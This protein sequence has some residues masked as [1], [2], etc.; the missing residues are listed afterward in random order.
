MVTTLEERVAYLEGRVEEQSRLGA[1]LREMVF[2]LDQKVDRYRE[3]L[4][5]EIRAVDQ[6][7]DQY[8]EELSAQIRTL[9]QRWSDRFQSLEQKV[10]D[11]D[12]RMVR[13]FIWIVG[14]QF[15]TLAT[16]ISL[17]LHF[18]FRAS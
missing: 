10:R 11:L 6:K 4:V 7:V 16:I 9:D 1:E 17:L 13:Y 14:F 3:E 8:R 15:A 2:H 18:L 12:Q 5:A